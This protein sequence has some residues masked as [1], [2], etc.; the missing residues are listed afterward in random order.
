MV[1]SVLH[2]SVT[3]AAAITGRGDDGSCRAD[4]V[5]A[6]TLSWQLSS[7]S[8]Y[9]VFFPTSLPLPSFTFTPPTVCHHRFH[10]LI[11]QGFITVSTHIT[12]IDRTPT[13]PTDWSSVGFQHHRRSRGAPLQHHH[14]AQLPCPHRQ[15]SDRQTFRGIFTC[16]SVHTATVPVSNDHC[17]RAS[18][19]L[20]VVS[21]T[22]IDERSASLLALSRKLLL[23]TLDGRRRKHPQ[24]QPK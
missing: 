20:V 4:T 5:R 6:D 11:K 8:S 9:H 17:Q 18:C 15:A 21:S 2:P 24:R 16:N 10:T 14:L 12:T 23:D 22:A 13:L 7:I 1:S 3:S 19:D